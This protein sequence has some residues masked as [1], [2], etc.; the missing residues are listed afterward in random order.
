MTGDRRIGDGLR[1][2]K[3]QIDWD[4][5]RSGGCHVTRLI[6]GTFRF[7]ILDGGVSGDDLARPQ[8]VLG[9]VGCTPNKSLSWAWR[10]GYLSGV[11]VASAGSVQFF[12]FSSQRLV[13]DSGVACFF[14][15]VTEGRLYNSVRHADCNLW[16]SE[17]AGPIT[18]HRTEGQGTSKYSTPYQYMGR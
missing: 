15:V 6:A 8:W 12:V 5:G 11:P 9:C 4:V 3:A 7:R 13:T 18:R 2:R 16:A 17:V 1:W 10:P 14:S